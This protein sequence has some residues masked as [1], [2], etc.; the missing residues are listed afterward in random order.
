MARDYGEMARHL[1]FRYAWSRLFMHSRVLDAMEGM[2]ASRK[3]HMVVEAGCFCSG[4]IHYLPAK[5]NLRYTG[6]DVSPVAL[7]VCR[8]LATEHGVGDRVSLF[9]GNFLQLRHEQLEAMTKQPLAGSV[10]LLC[11]FFSAVGSDWNLFPCL[12][13]GDYWLAYSALV[14]YWAS[15]G[16]IVVMCERNNAPAGIAESV[17]HFSM[18]IVDD[19]QCEV[20]SEFQTFVTRGMSVEN[21]LGEWVKEQACVVVAWSPS[22]STPR[23]TG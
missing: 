19:L 22:L 11:N 14:T 21:P 15:A 20:V 7:D 2:L 12:S 23:P 16:A 8:V 13:I 17:R 6:F 5:W 10:V 18:P 4:L 9:A 3:P 1:G